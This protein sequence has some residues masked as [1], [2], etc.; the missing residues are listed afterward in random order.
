MKKVRI[1]FN[2]PEKGEHDTTVSLAIDNM[3]VR[4]VRELEKLPDMIKGQYEEYMRLVYG[5][6]TPSQTLSDTQ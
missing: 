2:Y 5:L 4:S 1:E 3:D 6:P